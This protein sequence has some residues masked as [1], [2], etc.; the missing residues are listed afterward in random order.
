MKPLLALLALAGALALTAAAPAVGSDFSSVLSP[1]P[2]T[3]VMLAQAPA[4]AEEGLDLVF[5]HQKDAKQAPNRL[6]ISPQFRTGQ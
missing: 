4:A 1:G 2:A 5:Q 3:P 6:L